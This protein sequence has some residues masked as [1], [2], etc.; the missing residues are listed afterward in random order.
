MSHLAALD[1]LVFW[2]IG[3]LGGALLAG[4]VWLVLIYRDRRSARLDG[5]G[6]AGSRRSASE[7]EPTSMS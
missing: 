5:R 4:L 2:A 7:A 1:V 6:E 3:T